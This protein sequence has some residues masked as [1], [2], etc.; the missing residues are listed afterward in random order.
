MRVIHTGQALVDVTVEVPA[1]PQ[2]GQNAMASSYGRAAGGAVNILV[3][4]ARQGASCVHAGAIGTGDNGDLIRETL[5]AEGIGWSAP[6]IEDADTGV[7]LVM[8]EPSAERTFVTTQL[9]ERRLSVES[10]ATS[11]PQP[12]DLVCVTGYS[13]VVD[14]TCEPLLAWLE[15]LPASVQVVL[16]PGA[17]FAGLDAAVRDRM[18]ALTDV[19]TGNQEESTALAGVEGMDAAARALVDVLPREAVVIVRDGAEG[20]AVAESGRVAVVPGFPQTPIDTNGAGDAH[21]GILMAARALGLGWVEG[22]RRANAG[23][24][25]KVTRRGPA[26]APTASEIDAFLAQQTARRP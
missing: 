20:C 3:A 16:D 6:A 26:T 15:S 22:A 19:W 23:A 9:A 1:L 5:A 24:A 13:L 10:L 18:L 11:D 25:I 2:R 17:A 21:T 14:S 8:V 12:G 4:A 7:C